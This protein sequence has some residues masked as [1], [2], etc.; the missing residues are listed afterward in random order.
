M[1]P[2]TCYLERSDY[3]SAMTLEELKALEDSSKLSVPLQALSADRQGDWDRAH[4]LAQE[5]NN[6]DGDWVHA[7]LHA[8]S[9]SPISMSKRIPSM[10]SRICRFRSSWAQ[11][12]MA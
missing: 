5:A 1:K 8:R 4:T 12:P 6:R 10:N 3:G 2:D 11:S 7:Y 9:V